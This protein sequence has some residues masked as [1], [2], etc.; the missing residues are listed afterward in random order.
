FFSRAH[1]CEIAGGLRRLQD[2]ARTWIE[3]ADGGPEWR[4]EFTTTA[5]VMVSWSLR[6]EDD[7]VV[8]HLAFS[9]RQL[10]WAANGFVF[11]YVLDRL[12]LSWSEADVFSTGSPVVHAVVKLPVDRNSAAL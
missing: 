1:F 6:R 9:S 5:P 2:E 12:G 11:C 8:H 10:A 3:D 4:G 7:G